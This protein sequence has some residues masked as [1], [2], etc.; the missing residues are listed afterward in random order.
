MDSSCYIVMLLACLYAFKTPAKL[1]GSVDF[2]FGFEA[3]LLLKHF[4]FEA[5]L[6]FK[7]Y[8]FGA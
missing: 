8:G 2:S 1:S 4:G 7:C 6:L 5:R 3:R